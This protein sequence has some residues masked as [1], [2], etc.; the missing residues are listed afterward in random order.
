MEEHKLKAYLEDRG[1][2]KTWLA[3]QLGISMQALY[4][5]FSGVTKFSL[6]QSLKIRDLLRMTN[7][8]FNEVFGGNEK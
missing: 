4:Q 6:E 2:M 7:T 5:K 3:K 1:V 8:E